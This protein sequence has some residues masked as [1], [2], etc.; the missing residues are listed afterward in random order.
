MGYGFCMI[1]LEQVSKHYANAT[2]PSVRDVSLAVESESLLVLLGESGSGKTTT[3]KMVNRLIDATSGRVTI[4]GQDVRALD[5]IDLRRRIGYVFQGIGLFPHLSVRD[6]VAIVPE[7]LDWRPSEIDDRVDELLEL[8]GLQPDAFRSRLP[9][10]LS[11]GQQQR[12]GVARAL[13]AKSRV[14]LMDEPFGA[15]DPITRDEL[16]TELKRLQRSLGLTILLVTHDVTEALLLADR[17]AVMKDGALLAHDTP[18]RLLAEPPH[19]YVARLMAMP[20]RQAAR[21][22]AISEMP[23]DETRP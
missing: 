23:A 8:V 16:Q 9:A 17:I 14:L 10:A 13:A 20:K 19:D 22:A 18:A 1:R 6:N 15:V 11:G 3:L 4:Q 7:L 12:V 5:P 21:V 2:A